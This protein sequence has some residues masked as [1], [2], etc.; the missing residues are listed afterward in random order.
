M[1]DSLPLTEWSASHPAGASG[2]T[3]FD[4]EISF[5]LSELR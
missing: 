3:V 4:G 1:L 5:E 2:T